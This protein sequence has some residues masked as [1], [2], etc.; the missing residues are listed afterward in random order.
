MNVEPNDLNN[1][2]VIDPSDTT[3]HESRMLTHR[4]IVDVHTAT[5]SEMFIEGWTGEA[6]PAVIVLDDGT[7]LYASRDERG[8]GPGVM[9]MLC[10]VQQ[11]SHST[12]WIKRRVAIVPAD[13][14]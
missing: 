10:P 6:R 3:V 8:T 13:S 7:K 9:F 12:S 2:L 1:S 11:E 5:D 4:V 14:P